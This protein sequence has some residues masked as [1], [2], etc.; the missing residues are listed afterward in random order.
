MSACQLGPCTFLQLASLLSINA[1]SSTLTF[2][3]I[4]AMLTVED[5][6]FWEGLAPVTF[7]QLP[8]LQDQVT[9][10]G[11]ALWQSLMIRRQRTHF[12]VLLVP[13]MKPCCHA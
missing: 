5:E 7:G 12:H 9:V 2:A 1:C 3:C 6:A 13:T 10:I 11:Y 8:L 4:A